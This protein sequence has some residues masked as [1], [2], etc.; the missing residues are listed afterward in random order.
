MP[1]S[2]KPLT[3]ENVGNA[4]STARQLQMLLDRALTELVTY[5]EVRTIVEKIIDDAKWGKSP[6]REL[7]VKLITGKFMAKAEEAQ[8]TG[9]PVIM[10]REEAES[11]LREAGWTKTV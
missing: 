10:T 8:E 4:E 11:V 7:F 2:R 6:A 5:E 3:G 1:V 9:V